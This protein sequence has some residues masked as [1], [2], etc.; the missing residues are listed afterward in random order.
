MM[1]W[2]SVLRLPPQERRLWTVEIVG[3]GEMAT[4]GG[5]VG[6]ERFGLD[7]LA[8]LNPFGHIVLVR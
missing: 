6:R 5:E 2:C 1:T 8:W 3:T 7:C 4:C